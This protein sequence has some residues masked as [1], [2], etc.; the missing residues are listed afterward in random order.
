MTLAIASDLHDS[1]ENLKKFIKYLKKEDISSLLFCGDLCRAETL[2]Y[3][4]SNFPKKIH[5]IQ[6]NADLFDS[7]EP[8]RFK[9]INYHGRFANL[10]I[11]KLKIAIIHEPFFIKEI[12]KDSDFIFYGHTHLPKL[13]KKSLSYFANPGML[14]GELVQASFAILNTKNKLLE[15]KLLRDC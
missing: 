5:L 15:L 13:E 6:G 7:D 8:R 10:E 14:G 2:E 1:L 11:A 12:N 9:N 3:L 4:A